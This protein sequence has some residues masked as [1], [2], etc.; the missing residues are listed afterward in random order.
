MQLGELVDVLVHLDQALAVLLV[1]VLHELRIDEQSDCVC[2]VP[3]ISMPLA[4]KMLPRG[5]RRISV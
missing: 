4:S 2:T 5:A 1:T 3:A